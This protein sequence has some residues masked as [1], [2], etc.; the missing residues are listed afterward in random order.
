M[1]PPPVEGAT[2]ILS[3]FSQIGWRKQHFHDL[4]RSWSPREV[5]AF[6]MR[7]GMDGMPF[8]VVKGA[9]CQIQARYPLQR[10]VQRIRL[11]IVYYRWAELEVDLR[12]N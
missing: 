9:T 12:I 11:I 5:A 2:T 4:Q 7:L 3:Y 6:T 8:R 10:K 1:V